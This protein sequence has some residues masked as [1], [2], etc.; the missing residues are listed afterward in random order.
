MEKHKDIDAFI[1]PEDLKYNAYNTVV[2]DMRHNFTDEEILDMKEEVFQI[3][4][5]QSDRQDALNQFSEAMKKDYNPEEIKLLIDGLYGIDYGDEGIKS[6]KTRLR[7]N[8]QSIR[9][10][11]EIIK[12]KLFIFQYHELGLVAMYNEEGHY[13]YERAMTPA[14]RQYSITGNVR[15]IASK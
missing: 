4:K 9:S 3:N 2:E 8:L 15:N 12:K 14:E 13:E 11:Y 7:K 5:F 6:L 10:G 1:N